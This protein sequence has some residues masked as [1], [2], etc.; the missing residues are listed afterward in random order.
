[1]IKVGNVV[2]FESG[3]IG[4]PWTL[5]ALVLGTS[6]SPGR[7]RIA[8][9]R[10][11][12]APCSRRSFAFVTSRLPVASRFGFGYAGSSRGDP[13]PVEGGV[14]ATPLPWEYDDGGR[15]EAG[16]KGSASD[17]ACRAVAIAT[18]RPYQEVYDTIKALARRERP[19]KE[20]QR[21]CP[22]RGVRRDLMKKLMACYGWSWTPTM[23]IGSGCTTHLAV[24]E[25]P[26]GRLITALSKHYSAD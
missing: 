1:M 14:M 4:E 16:Y 25:L 26:Q 2:E 19:K 17:C 23:L 9:R 20:S 12:T 7:L 6:P 24:G 15:V 5:F 21:S 13:S 10:E 11:Q 22:R 18:G 3:L 8:V